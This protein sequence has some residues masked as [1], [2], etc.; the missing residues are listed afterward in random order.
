[1]KETKNRKRLHLIA[2]VLGA[3]AVFLGFGLILAGLEDLQGA[4]GPIRILLG[5]GM[6][7]FGFYGAVSY[8]HLTLPTIRLV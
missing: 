7:G 3:Y 5:L 8:T 1:M 4:V 2:L 6:M